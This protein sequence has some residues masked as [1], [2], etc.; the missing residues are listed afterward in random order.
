MLMAKKAH[1]RRGLQEGDIGGSHCSS[2]TRWD[3]IKGDQTE[4][5]NGGS[6]LEQPVFS[7]ALLDDF[8]LRSAIC[9]SVNMI[10]MIVEVNRLSRQQ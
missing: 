1:T 9:F 3:T 8:S 4:I 10:I 6:H 2:W 5:D 7:T